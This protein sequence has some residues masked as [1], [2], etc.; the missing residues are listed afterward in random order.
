MP[1]LP[2]PLLPPLYCFQ[3]DSCF[4]GYWIDLSAAGIQ[5]VS[6]MHEM[7]AEKSRR[8]AL[9]AVWC[10]MILYCAGYELQPNL[11]SAF[12]RSYAWPARWLGPA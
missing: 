11:D 4:Q 9:V 1:P 12:S 6:L 10:I 8:F 3:T 7:S 2:P 5:P